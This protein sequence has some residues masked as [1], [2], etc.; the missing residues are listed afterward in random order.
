MDAAQIHRESASG[1]P[2]LVSPFLGEDCRPP[3]HSNIDRIGNEPFFIFKFQS[4]LGSIQGEHPQTN[5]Y[6]TWCG[7][8]RPT[9]SS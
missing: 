7:G 5:S 3:A 2:C 6:D 9:G 4:G 1:S 8:E